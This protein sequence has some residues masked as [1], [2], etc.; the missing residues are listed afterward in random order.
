MGDVGF[1]CFALAK[2]RR[3]APPALAQE[4]AAAVV[5]PADG[6]FARVAAVGPYVNFTVSTPALAR[7][8]A[9]AALANPDGWGGSDEGAGRVVV[10]DYSSPNIAKPLGVHHIRSTMIG[11]ALARIYAACGWKVVR[12]NYL[13]DWGTTFGQLAVAYA[14]AKTRNPAQ[15]VDVGALRR[16]YVAFH[17]AA[18]EDESLGDEARAWF[19]RLE[20]GDAE[21]RALWRTFVDE[22]V[23][24]LKKLYGRLGV[25]FD[26]YDG[27][28]TH[29]EALEPLAK[30]LETMGL[31]K[32]SDGAKVVDLEDEGMPPL[33]VRKRDGATTY[34]TRD[35]A[36]AEHRRD[37]Y[38]CDRS[39]YV[40]ANQQELHFRQ[41]FAVLKRMGYAN[42]DD[43]CV[44]VKF[45]M[46]AF[47]PGV[48]GEGQVTGATRKGRVVFLEDVLDRAVE[49][50]RAFIAENAR[51]ADIDVAAL[52][53]QV[54]VG[55]VVFSEFL[56]RRTKDV[57][58]T[59]EKA[60]NLQGDSGPYLQY[61][62]ARLSTVRR[63][64]EGA[65]D[66][67]AV[68][69]SRLKSPL[70]K[71]VLSVV[72]AFPGVVS[73]ARREDE[74]SLVAT[75]LLELCAVF[76]R[77][78]TDKENHRI[79]TEDAALTAARVGLVEAVRLTLA[80]GL[81]LLGLAAPER[82]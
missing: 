56:Q 1:P 9:A 43:V 34:A 38:R 70:E 42:V 13:G 12:V 39:L 60:L 17:A 45:G 53:E 69:W 28:S 78:F 36:A 62:H 67:A 2:E 59:W 47:G 61:T 48:F 18:E 72:G 6:P 4:M 54:G 52:A 81:G 7:R 20:D 14:Q 3:K 63:K 35:L 27:E 44:H 49:K 51:D 46:L 82:M 58:F 31:L 57:L 79:L 33:L 16:L 50:A 11:A 71:E 24:P 76:N 21:A 40:V 77:M 15:P 68:D 30:R 73:Q 66:P 25:E 10:M 19:K 80:R 5:L 29:N 37:A 75:Y 64:Y 74:P 41:V 26:R 32:I 55:A 23:K 22:S 65:L 8:S